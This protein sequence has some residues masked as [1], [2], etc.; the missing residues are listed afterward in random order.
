[1]D[2][3]SLLGVQRNASDDA[4]ARAYR[5]LA[6]RYHPGVNPG[7]RLAETMYRQVQQAYEILADL[8]RRR[9]Y[10]RGV[11][12]IEVVAPEA[13]VAFAGFDFSQ[14]AEG[15]LAATFSELFAEVF[16]DAAREATTPTQGAP[17]E[18]TVRVPFETAMRGGEA[19][20]SVTRQERCPTCAGDG[21]VPR[22]PATCPVCGGDGER[23]WARG[24]MHFT[25]ACEEC[26]GV[27]RVTSQACRP[28]SG[29]GVQAR[30]E[31]VTIALPPGLETGARLVVPG[32]CTS[33][34]TSRLTRSSVA[35][36]AT[37][38]SRSR[39]R[40]TKRRSARV[41]TC[42]RSRGPRPCGYRPARSQVRPCGWRAR[43]CPRRG[44][45]PGTS[46]AKS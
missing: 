27:G 6:R 3:Y 17:I 31:V 13:S 10:D 43:A 41:S 35:K 16:H 24:H 15:P 37:S 40:S 19:P 7:D 12:T 45:S 34:S 23:R 44:A 30:S 8:E 38:T 21:R 11:I 14:P 36:G 18:I 5:R 26:S 9:E 32:T 22:P 4:I 25:K 46:S 33:P 2:L 28:C 39:S 20:V 1:M 42:R 29:T